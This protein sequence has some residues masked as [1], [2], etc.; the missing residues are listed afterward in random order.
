M[1]K[2]LVL[3]LLTFAVFSLTSEA[4]ASGRRVNVNVRGVN[5][6]PALNARSFRAPVGFRS[7]FYGSNFRSYSYSNFGYAAPVYYTSPFV[8]Y[9]PAPIVYYQP[10][11]IVYAPPAYTYAPPPAAAPL[12]YAPPANVE[13]PS[14][15]APAP[16]AVELPVVSTYVLNYVRTLPYAQ[17]VEFFNTFYGRSYGNRL[18]SH[19]FRGNNFRGPGNFKNTIRGNFRR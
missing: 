5:R 8:Y 11:P 4:D 1:K 9:Q 14:Y 12:A 10:A 13:V 19:H 16:L 7:N 15:S 3:S 2:L 17:G 6:G 18:Y